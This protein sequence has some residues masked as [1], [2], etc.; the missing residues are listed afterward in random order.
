PP[1]AFGTADCRSGRLVS[2][3]PTQGG[4]VTEP[5]PMMSRLARGI[6]LGRQGSLAAAR[7]T[8][9][10]LWHELGPQGD[11]LLRCSVAHSMADVQDDPHDELRWDLRALDAAEE[12]TDAR[13][14]SAGMGTSARA[15]YPSLHLNLA[16]A[17]RTLG[18]LDHAGDHLERGRATA[19]ALGD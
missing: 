3:R 13:V 11:A 10:V 6:E 5:H 15:L 16:E 1:R 8:F 19:D 18:Q 9:T 7:T 17:Y 4:C 2:L 14:R 12:I